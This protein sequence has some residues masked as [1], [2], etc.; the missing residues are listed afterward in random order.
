[1][2]RTGLGAGGWA[3]DLQLLRVKLH[4]SKPEI[5]KVKARYRAVAPEKKKEKEE[6]EEEEGVANVSAQQYIRV[7]HTF[8]NA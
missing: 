1:M 2:R 5:Q 7:S 8:V 3:R 4:V 6:E